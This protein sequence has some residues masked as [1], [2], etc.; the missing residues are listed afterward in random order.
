[1]KI[2]AESFW[3]VRRIF[4]FKVLFFAS[5]DFGAD[6]VAAEKSYYSTNNST[7]NCSPYSSERTC[8]NSYMCSGFSTCDCSCYGTANTP[9]CFCFSCH[10]TTP[11]R[12]FCFLNVILNFVSC[13]K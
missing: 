10:Y 5:V 12:F 6:F 4:V 11:L 13:I 9:N 2:P 7:R 8:D 1:M 3:G